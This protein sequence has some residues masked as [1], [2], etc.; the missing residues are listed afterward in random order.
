MGRV[1]GYGAS[2]AG[3]PVVRGRPARPASKTRTVGSASAARSSRSASVRV[4]LSS[5]GIRPTRAAPRPAQMRSAD[6]PRRKATRSPRCSPGPAAH[7]RPGA[8]DLGVGASGARRWGAPGTGQRTT[9]AR[10]MQATCDHGPWLTAAAAT[11]SSG[12]ERCS[13][14]PAGWWCSPGPAFRPTRASPTSAGR[15]ACGPRTPRPRSGDPRLYVADPELRER[16][17]QNRLTSPMWAAEPNAGHRALVELE[18]IGPARHSGD[19][20]HR[21]AAPARPGTTR[22]GSSRSTAPRSRSCAWLRRPPAGRAGARPGAGRA[23]RTRP[24]GSGP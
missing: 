11:T 23:S 3:G 9:T 17:W 18:R 15:K 14:R 13:S 10:T 5:T 16:A 7:R 2:S 21:R 1:S 12:P 20:E 22:R 6:E 4:A 19:P 24:A 8:G